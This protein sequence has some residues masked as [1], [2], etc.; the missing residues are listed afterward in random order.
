MSTAGRR[1]AV[2]VA[3]ALLAGLLT[4]ASH[5]LAPTQEPSPPAP[6]VLRPTTSAPGAAPTAAGVSAEV[7]ALVRRLGSNASALIVDP[8]TGTVLLARAE[9]RPLTPASTTKL[10]TAAAALDVLGPQTRLSTTTYRLDD[11]IYLV[12]GGDPTLVSTGGG[13]PDAGGSASMRELARSTAAKFTALTTVRLVYDA[14]L[15]TGPRLG[16]GWKSS[17]PSAGVAAPVS[18]LVVDGGHPSRGARAFVADPARQAAKVFAGFLRGQGLNVESVDAGVVDAK[19]EQ[20]AQVQSATVQD[21]VESMLTESDN[22]EA[23]ALAHLVGGK[24]LGNASFAG[25]AEATEQTLRT[26]GVDVDGVSLAD[27]SGVSTRN[28]IPAETLAGILAVVTRGTDADLAAIGPG[29]PVA[30]L[31]GTLADRFDTAATRPGRGVVHAK[32]GTLTGVAT[33]AGT[34]RTREGRVLVFALLTNGVRSLD[35]ARDRMDEI[36]SRLATCGCTQA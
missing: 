18:A 2:A 21:I 1:A 9:S 17:Y 8:S 6:S 14:S 25:G 30:G 24:V 29:L 33:L 26:L 34:V 32:T 3:L 12:G 23:E 36:A 22:N 27:G 28:R 11:T 13:N 10:T 15:F 35:A 7:G 19:A 31:T 4:P 20:V 5:A 16:P